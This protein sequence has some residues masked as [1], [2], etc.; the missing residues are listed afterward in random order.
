MGKSKQKQNDK[1][2]SYKNKDT[3]VIEPPESEEFL[4]S[5]EFRQFIMQRRSGPLPTPEEFDEYNKVLPGAADRIL[6]MAEDLTSYESKKLTED[7]KI[8]SRNSLLGLIF[9]FLTSTFVLI[10][11]YA[12]IMKGEGLV[13]LGLV[14]AELAALITAFVYNKNQDNEEDE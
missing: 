11:S 3:K 14:V 9:A 12:A 8:K 2:K 13:S 10:V 7:S 4:Q 1:L 5:P 6:K